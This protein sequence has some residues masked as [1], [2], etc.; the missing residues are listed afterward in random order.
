MAAVAESI[1]ELSTPAAYRPG[2]GVIVSIFP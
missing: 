2:R 1:I